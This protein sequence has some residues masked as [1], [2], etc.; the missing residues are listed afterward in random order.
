MIVESP[1]VVYVVLKDVL[2]GLE[3]SYHSLLAVE[4][5]SEIGL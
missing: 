3:G 4:V 5:V 1:E 2:K